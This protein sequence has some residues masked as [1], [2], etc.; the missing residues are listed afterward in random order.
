MWR[1]ARNLLLACLIALAIPH[2]LTWGQTISGGGGSM[3]VP[4]P[5]PSTLGGIVA[6]G[7]VTNQFITGI[8][9]QGV[10]IRA[11]PTCSNLSDAGTG[12]T[13]FCYSA[14]G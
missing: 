3:T 2:A 9:D 8:D 6:W 5:T 7:P 12:G 1:D 4:P 13:S 14:N 11:Q 10:P